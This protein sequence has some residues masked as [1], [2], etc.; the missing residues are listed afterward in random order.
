MDLHPALKSAMDGGVVAVDF[1]DVIPLATGPEAEDNTLKNPARISARASRSLWM[2]VL[3]EQP[4]DTLPF[5]FNGTGEQCQIAQRAV[6]NRLRDM[7][8]Y[9]LLRTL[10]H[11]TIP[12]H[13]SPRRASDDM[14]RGMRL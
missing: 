3:V 12:V 13:R 5:L 10:F 8:L 9:H 4:L 6:V 2:I 7:A 14:R 1:W 11:R